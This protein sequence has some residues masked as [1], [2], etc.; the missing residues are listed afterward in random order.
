MSNNTTA[1]KGMSHKNEVA[2][3]KRLQRKRYR[4]I[5]VLYTSTGLPFNYLDNECGD[6]LDLTLS[7]GYKERVILGA[8]FGR[9]WANHTIDDDDSETDCFGDSNFL[10][11]R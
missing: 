1:L 3:R 8:C 10:H 7:R 5:N 6:V 11:P 4:I 2:R 9:L